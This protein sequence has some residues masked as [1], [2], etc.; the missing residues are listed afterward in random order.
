MRKIG[1]LLLIS[2][3]INPFILGQANYEFGEIYILRPLEFAGGLSKVN[4]EIN[5]ELICKIPNGS[6]VKYTFY[7][8][9]NYSIGLGYYAKKTNNLDLTAKTIYVTKGEKYYFIIDLS[10]SYERKVQQTDESYG[11][12]LFNEISNLSYWKF[13]G[14]KPYENLT[15]NKVS[16]ENREVQTNNKLA[17]IKKVQVSETMPPI[18][19]KE[20]EKIIISDIDFDIPVNKNKYNYRFALIIGNEDYSSKNPSL[21]GEINVE[22][23]LNDAI[24]FAQYAKAL[25][26]I[27]EENI[28][29]L[30]NGTSI[31]MRRAV[32]KMNLIAKNMNGN[33][34]LFL[35][36]SGHGLP[37]YNTGEPYLIPVDVDGLDLDYAI[38]LDELYKKL[39]EYPTKRTTV[40]LDACFSGGARNNSLLTIRGIK[41][42]PKQEELK[43]RLVVFSASQNEQ[44]ALSYQN[45]AHGIFTYYL[46]KKLKD[47][48]GKCTYYELSEYL[49]QIVSIKSI[50]INNIEQNPQTSI[51]EMI[52]EEWGNWSF[53]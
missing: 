45:Q 32:N 12:E 25:L 43:G 17:N 14:G 48:G 29:I 13:E 11:K 23:A 21:S 15:E 20:K 36:Y 42:K 2:Y 33:A 6:K 22:Y 51:S 49:N 35:Y 34:E 39:S 16:I 19:P 27:P 50:I 30:Q 1:I 18:D 4:I 24:V 41:I 5:N 40:F 9:G 52:K 7:K 38:P 10:K 31:E 28:T 47:S 44:A 53:Y 26:G 3:M 37:D 8:D 46:L